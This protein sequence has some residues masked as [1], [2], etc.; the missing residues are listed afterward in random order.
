VPDGSRVV[1]VGD[2]MLVRVWDTVGGR[3]LHTLAGHARQTP[4][5]H[6]T[7]LY[8]V[9]ISP[10]GRYAASGDRIGAVLIWDLLAAKLVSQFHVPIL[11][12]YDPRQRKRSIGGIR[13]LA[14][15]PDGR[16]L[17]AGGIGQVGNVDGLAGPASV[18]VWDWQT[19]RRALAANAQEHKGI[20][21]HLLFHP[22][23]PWLIGVGGGSDNGFLAFWRTDSLMRSDKEQRATG[24]GVR[25]KTDGHIHR[26]YLDPLKNELYTAG[27]HKVEV[28]SLN[29]Q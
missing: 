6:V 17:A 20:V 29:A 13:T 4:Q 1:T 12:T 27:Y 5:G 24:N 23:E 2:D 11:Y 19:P 18:E 7:A 3:L 8:A 28:W 26:A 25:V 16:L 15:S 21:N 14:F 22:R 10:D 9:A